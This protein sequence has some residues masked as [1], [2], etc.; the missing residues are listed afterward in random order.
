M[1]K[2]VGKS[3]RVVETP[4]LSIDEFAGNVGSQDDT[5]SL[6]VVKVSAP[7]SEPWLTL[8]YDEWLAILKGKTEFYFVNP[9]TGQ[10]EKITAVAGDTVFV[11]KGERFRPVFPEGGTEYVPVCIPA[12]RPDRCLREEEGGI[13]TSDVA[14][15]LKTLHSS[16][17]DA[18]AP[19]CGS[20]S[21]NTT[22]TTTTTT[23]SSQFSDVLYH[24]CEKDKWDEAVSKQVAYYP[25]TFVADGHFTHAT[26]VATRLIET[27]NH[28]YTSSKSEW[29]CLELSAQVLKEKCGIITTFEEPK[30]VGDQDVSKQWESTGWICPHIFG[31]IPTTVDGVVLKTYK[32]TREMDTGKFL[33]IEGL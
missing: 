31:G 23:P 2:I 7:S 11:A 5:M 13:N 16:N 25:P 14:D 9:T 6:A 33:K 20:V 26:A 28:F 22:T 1:P 29:I 17:G 8:D 27:A 21:T 15:K 12:F 18:A 24:M 19:T 10:E 32:M 30:P 3:T 4:D